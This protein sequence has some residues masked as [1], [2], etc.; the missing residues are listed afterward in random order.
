MRITAVIRDDTPGEQTA[1]GR[2]AKARD[3]SPNHTGTFSSVRS[4]RHQSER[5]SRPTLP[6]RQAIQDEAESLHE[7]SGLDCQI[8][9]RQVDTTFSGRSATHEVNHSRKQI[10]SKPA[11]LAPYGFIAGK[12][13]W[14][15]KTR[16][17]SLLSIHVRAAPPLVHK[18]RAFDGARDRPGRVGRHR[19]ITPKR[20]QPTRH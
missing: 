11:Y 14:F 12:W 18:A 13:A 19:P 5:W 2:V 8:Y 7:L 4:R 20:E 9:P 6:T 3:V 16:E 1:T 10:T 17:V 15:Q